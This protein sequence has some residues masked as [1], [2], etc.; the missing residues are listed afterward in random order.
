MTLHQFWTRQEQVIIVEKFEPSTVITFL[1]TH[2]GTVHS[3]Q[4]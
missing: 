3:T 4:H 1:S 2:H